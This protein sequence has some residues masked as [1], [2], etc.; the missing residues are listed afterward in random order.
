M[1]LAC[2]RIGSFAFLI[3]Y[4]YRHES[5]L[6]LH[7]D[8]GSVHGPSLRI[9]PGTAKTLIAAW[10]TMGKQPQEPEFWFEVC[11]CVHVVLYLFLATPLNLG[12]KGWCGLSPPGALEVGVK[13]LERSWEESCEAGSRGLVSW[14][15]QSRMWR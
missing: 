14:H 10:F 7:V 5:T 3:A 9:Q 12:I 2:P 6:F 8:F 4:V 13:T 11:V 15:V 1:V